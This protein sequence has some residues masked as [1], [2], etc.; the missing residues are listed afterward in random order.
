MS[1]RPNFIGLREAAAAYHISRQAI[2]NAIHN[3]ELKAYK[4]CGRRYTV[5]IADFEAWIMTKPA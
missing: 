4:P 5:R 3:G 1:I 2:L